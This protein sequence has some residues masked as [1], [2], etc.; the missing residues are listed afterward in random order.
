MPISTSICDHT[1]THAQVLSWILAGRLSLRAG[2]RAYQLESTSCQVISREM[3]VPDITISQSRMVLATT[4]MTPMERIR[5]RAA[6]LVS[7]KGRI[8]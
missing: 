2:L 8:S 6:T 7:V 5:A 4:G 3:G 1:G